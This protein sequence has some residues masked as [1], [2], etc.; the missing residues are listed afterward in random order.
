MAA[1]S[2]DLGANLPA[3]RT[4]LRF[5]QR[6]AHPGQRRSGL[7]RDVAEAHAPL[8][9][10]P[11]PVVGDDV[12]PVI[13]GAGQRLC[14]ICHYPAIIRRRRV[15]DALLQRVSAPSS[16]QQTTRKP[17]PR[18]PSRPGRPGRGAGAREGGNFV[19]G[20]KITSTVSPASGGH[21]PLPPCADPFGRPAPQSAEYHSRTCDFAD[22]RGGTR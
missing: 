22:I 15:K 21:F 16:S 5:T 1:R 18:K 2:A 11:R 4:T 3:H 17:L 20:G 14:A 19:A 12:H 13:I 8:V 7:R 6:G 10:P 9:H